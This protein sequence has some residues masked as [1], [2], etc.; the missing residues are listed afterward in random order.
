MPWRHGLDEPRGCGRRGAASPCVMHPYRRFFP[1][2]LPR[3]FTLTEVSACHLLPCQGA[4]LLTSAD[5]GTE[6]P[7]P[8]LDNSW[9]Q[10]LHKSLIV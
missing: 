8:V 6:P 1:G 4:G 3:A 2:P 9:Q 7:L 5:R 10:H